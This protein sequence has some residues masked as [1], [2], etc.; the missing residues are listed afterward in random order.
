[1]KEFFK[2]IGNDTLK[3]VR[4]S[5]DSHMNDAFFD[6]YNTLNYSQVFRKHLEMLFYQRILYF[7]FTPKRCEKRTPICYG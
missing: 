4:E 3:K 2:E 7:T 5:A 1:M 6:G